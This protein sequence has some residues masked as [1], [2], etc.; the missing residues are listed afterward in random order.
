[1]SPAKKTKKSVSMSE[2]MEQVETK[3]QEAVQ[4]QAQAQQV[5][6]ANAQIAKENN[7]P[8]QIPEVNPDEIPQGD[9]ILGMLGYLHFACILPLILR[10]ES[11]FCQFHGKQ[12]LVITMCFLLF[13]IFTKF[14]GKYFLASNIFVTVLWVSLA[15]FGMVQAYK[16]KMTK[17]PG[18]GDVAK[19]LNWDNQAK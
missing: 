1:M 13:G 2:L 7:V 9:K 15:L 19:L 8:T 16:G 6:Q 5:Q 4:A 14:M 12:G 10:Q 17:I 3:K 18:F 11:K